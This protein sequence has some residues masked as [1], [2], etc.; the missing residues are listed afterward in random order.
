MAAPFEAAAAYAARLSWPVFPCVG[1]VP[2]IQG[3]RGCLD[4]TMDAPTIGAWWSEYPGANIGIATGAASMVWALD[5]DG[6][7]GRQSIAELEHE[8]RPLPQ[9]V[10]QITGS[11]GLHLLF[12][13]DLARPVR[14]RAGFRLGLDTRGDGGYII[15]APSI[16][17]QTGRRYEWRPDR[18]PLRRAIASAP[19][20]LLEVVVPSVEASPG[21]Q[22]RPTINEDV[23]WGPKPRYSRAALQQACEAI[24]AAP[25]G[26]QDQTLNRE[27]YSIGRLIGAGLM[28]R[29]LAVECLVY[30]ATLMSNAPGRRRWREREIQQKVARAVR[31]GELRPREVL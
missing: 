25:V 1:K 17:P 13:Y 27:A 22:A 5:I 2:A 10:E 18:H 12:K 19:D 29:R 9:T 30:H 8:R 24:E 11:G 15:V 31:Q 20:W 3:G 4:A 16:H 7:A 28:P 23:G 26:Q 6:E 21:G 14:N